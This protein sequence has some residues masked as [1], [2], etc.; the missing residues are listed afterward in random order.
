MKKQK[1]KNIDLLIAFQLY[2]YNKGKIYD[3]DWDFEK[4]AKKFLKSCIREADKI[5]KKVEIQFEFDTAAAFE[6]LTKLKEQLDEIQ[7]NLSEVKRSNR[8]DKHPLDIDNPLPFVTFEKS[9]QDVMDEFKAAINTVYPPEGDTPKVAGMGNGRRLYSKCN[10]G[11]VV[12]SYVE[13]SNLN[14]G[15][16]VLVIQCRN[17][18]KFVVAGDHHAPTY[19]KPYDQSSDTK[20]AD[21]E[22]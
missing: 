11:D 16:Y 22:K 5:D 20:K 21:N 9:D 8:G 18:K 3:T 1:Q 15:F 17:G 7:K 6:S 19:L 10:R 4:Q 13:E 14:K 12:R 2:L